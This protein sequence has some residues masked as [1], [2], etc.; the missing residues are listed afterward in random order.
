MNQDMV[1]IIIAISD[2]LY[3]R[4]N[5]PKTLEKRA[6]IAIAF[7]KKSAYNVGQTSI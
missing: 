2:M 6:K 7:Q 3:V 5:A 4:Q 1:D